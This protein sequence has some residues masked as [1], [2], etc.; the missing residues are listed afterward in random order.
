LA[1]QFPN[2]G[3]HTTSDIHHVSHYPGTTCVEGTGTPSYD[4]AT[5]V[6]GQGVYD[7]VHQFG[8]D[9][10]R[11][12]FTYKGVDVHITNATYCF[13]E[14]E[15][16]V[17]ENISALLDD[18]IGDDDGIP[19][20]GDHS[21][22]SG[23]NP[24]VGGQIAGCDDNCPAVSNPNQEDGDCDGTGDACDGL[25][26]CIAGVDCDD[27]CDGVPNQTDNCQYYWNPSQ[28]DNDS[29]SIGNACDSNTDS[30]GDGWGD[31]WAYQNTCINFW[32]QISTPM[33]MDMCDNCPDDYNPTQQDT[34]KD[35]LG[36][37]CDP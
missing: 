34:D 13:A 31:P 2:P 18:A 17:E 5:W 25:T 14:K 36:D 1:N 3:M 16:A 37:A 11:S 26:N 20:D 6:P 8:T 32:M 22:T 21:G 15:Q 29:D 19:A 23:D 33:G 7:E 35:G 10:Y 28:A 9:C 30:D 4:P 12:D 24:C 27:D